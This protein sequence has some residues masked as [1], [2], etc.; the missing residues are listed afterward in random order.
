M[1]KDKIIFWT[2][3]I[4]IFLFEGVMPA[5]TSQTE[6]AKEGIRHLGYP[7]YFG[8]ALVVFKVLGSLIL[9]IPQLP[10]RVKEWAYAGFAFDFIFASISHTAVDGFTFNSIF[11]LIVFAVLIVS[12]VYYHKIYS[13]KI[14]ISKD[15]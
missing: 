7:E 6:L 15:I 14:S 1:K 10:K 4:L 13:S 9:I 11:P 2:A 3:T 5:F 8:N 12:Y